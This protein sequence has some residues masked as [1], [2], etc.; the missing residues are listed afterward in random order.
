ME[1]K[2]LLEGLK[3]SDT[4]TL[5]RTID[6]YCAYVSAVIRN[7]LGSNCIEADVEELASE[8]FFMLWQKRFSIIT[9]N[10]RGWLGVVAKNQARSFQRKNK[11]CTTN[12]SI[13]DVI[14]VDGDKS[15]RLL[16]KKE[17]ARILHIALQELGEPDSIILTWYY[18]ENIPVSSIAAK[19]QMH[20]EAVKSRIRRGRE[21]LKYIL[22]KE[23]YTV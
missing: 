3:K 22:R 18:Y 20:P 6:Y 15:V 16:E 1:D 14:I 13:D 11:N 8:V 10:L 9:A 5:E 4:Q 19:L 23:G 17:R 7:Q 21:K 2:V 12:V